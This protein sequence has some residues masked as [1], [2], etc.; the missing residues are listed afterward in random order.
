MEM[1]KTLQ[2][3]AKDIRNCLGSR[4]N[5]HRLVRG[6][7]YCDR[8]YECAETRA[9]LRYLSKTSEKAIY[10]DCDIA[11]FS[12]LNELTELLESHDI[13][14]IPHMLTPLPAP[15]HH[16]TPLHLALLFPTLD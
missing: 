10:L 9:F 7:I 15:E 12:R 1:K 4:H 5:S 3:L 13:A 14:L 8:V 11:V 16:H 6:Q 2:T